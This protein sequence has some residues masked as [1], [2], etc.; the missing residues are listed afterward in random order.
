MGLEDR[1]RAMLAWRK[2]GLPL[3]ISVNLSAKQFYREDCVATDF[4]NRPLGGCEPSWIELEVTET[5]LVHDIDAIRKVL[6]QL[7][8]EGFTVAIDDFGTGYSSLTHLK[9]FPIDTLKIDISFI[10]DLETDPATRRSRKR[11]SGSRAASASRWSRRASVH[12]EQ[13]E[14]LDVRGCHYFQGYWV[15]KPLP[16]ENFV[17]FVMRKPH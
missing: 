2:S 13:L 17:E 9:H 16:A 15:S 11:S 6:H 10:A 1:G 4:G 3:T 14:F 8:D 5:S 7:R 12:R